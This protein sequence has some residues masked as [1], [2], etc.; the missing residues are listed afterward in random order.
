M[1][2]RDVIGRR[3]VRIRQERFR[4]KNTGCLAISLCW[5]ELDDGT[6]ISFHAAES[7]VDPY[8]DAML[9]KTSKIIHGQG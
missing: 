1:K 6:L 4:N 8:V 5:I 9:T 2:A 3:I 7:H